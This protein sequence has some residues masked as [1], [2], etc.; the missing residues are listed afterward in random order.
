MKLNLTYKHTVLACYI[1]YIVQAIV[2]TL[3]PLL[4]VVYSE[5]LGLSLLQISVLITFNFVIQLAVDIA[6]TSFITHLGY[7]RGVIL[8][9]LL[10]VTGLILMPTLTALMASKFIALLISSTVMCAGGGLIEVIVSP[11]VEAIPGDKKASDMSI[12]HSFYCWGQVIVVLITT[13]YLTVFGLDAWSFLPIIFAVFPIS[14]G[15]MYALVPI[16]QLCEDGEKRGFSH[17]ARQRGFITMIIIMVCAGASEV[18]LSQWA[19]LF[20]EKGLGIS[21]SLGDLLGPCSFAVA[22]GLSRVIFGKCASRIRLEKWML[23]S[24]ILCTIS[25]L[26]TVF[27]TIPAL[28]FFGFALCGISVAIL[29]PGTY[30]LGAEFIPTGGTL[31][32]ALFAFSGDLGCTLGPDLI[33]IV[34]DSVI[35]NGSFLTSLLSGDETALALKVGIL[36]AIVFPI[37]G[38]ISAFTLIH[39]MNYNRNHTQNE[40]K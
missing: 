14:A 30:S 9:E 29:W 34:S 21:K 4:F 18:A 28:S 26:I 19:S 23:A 3:S 16:N 33:G 38:A 32:F 11:I 17:L 25:Y 12:L 8:A 10:V 6:S 37:I 24:F 35:K 20:A 22:M 15:I 13:L 39:K 31:M 36:S 5:R 40:S 27:S 1:S 2:N 7:R